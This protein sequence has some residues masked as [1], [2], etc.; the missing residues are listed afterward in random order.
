L[1]TAIERIHILLGT[2]LSPTDYQVLKN[3]LVQLEKDVI[4]LNMLLGDK[5]ER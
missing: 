3:K 5:E 2:D 4:D 1:N